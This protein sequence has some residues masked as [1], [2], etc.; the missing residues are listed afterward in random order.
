VISSE[1]NSY[2]TARTNAYTA[3]SGLSF[4]SDGPGINGGGGGGGGSGG[5]GGGGGGG[6]G[7]GGPGSGA[8]VGDSRWVEVRPQ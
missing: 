8:G 3:S 5:G 1:P 2:S 7:G 4:N 6:V